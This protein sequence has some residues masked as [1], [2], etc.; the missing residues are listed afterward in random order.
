MQI[1]LGTLREVEIERVNE[2]LSQAIMESCL[3]M[4]IFREEFNTSFVAMFVIL[5]FVKT[6]HWLLQ[7]RVEYIDTM[8]VVPLKTRL[9]ITTF[10]LTLLVSP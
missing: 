10:M 8:P 2:R 7:D 1:F 5:T 9:R 6:F 4:T 3:A